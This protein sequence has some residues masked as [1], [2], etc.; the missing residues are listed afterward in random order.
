MQTCLLVR[1]NGR[2]LGVPDKILGVGVTVA[3]DN[4]TLDRHA[5]AESVVLEA[6]GSTQ[7]PGMDLSERKVGEEELDSSQ[8]P[9]AILGKLTFVAGMTRPGLPN[10]VR[11]LGR[12]PSSPCVRH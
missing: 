5:D 11:E 9:Y 8:L 4:T 3:H 1:Y 2:N 12:R 7:V 10:V 6:M